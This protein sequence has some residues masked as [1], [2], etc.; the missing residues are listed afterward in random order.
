MN[1]G[2][3]VSGDCTTNANIPYVKMTITT[4]DNDALIY[5]IKQGETIRIKLQ[6]QTKVV[7]KSTNDDRDQEIYHS[8]RNK[9]DWWINQYRIRQMPNT[10]V[11]KIFNNRTSQLYD[12]YG[13]TYMDEY[14]STPVGN[15]YVLSGL[16]ENIDLWIKAQEDMFLVIFNL[17]ARISNTLM[18]TTDKLFSW[19]MNVSVEEVHTYLDGIYQT[20]LPQVSEMIGQYLLDLLNRYVWPAIATYVATNAIAGIVRY[21]R[22]IQDAQPIIEEVE[23]AIIPL[24]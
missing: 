3:T 11:A 8:G 5:P 2:N 19:Y 6:G 12:V 20:V 16:G 18:Q 9:D 21:Q 22:A 24:Q 17:G 4:G 14:N 7:A 13:Y 15:E 23:D 10:D 1:D